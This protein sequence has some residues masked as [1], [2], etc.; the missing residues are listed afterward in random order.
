MPLVS[1]SRMTTFSPCMVGMVA[2]RMS[3]ARPLTEKR[4]RPILG[5]PPFGDV[6]PG[7][8]LDTAHE[9]GTQPSRWGHHVPQDPVDAVTDLQPFTVG[10]DMD[11][12]CVGADRVRDDLIDEADH[13]RFLRQI[14]EVLDIR[15]VGA[16]A[17]HPDIV[18]DPVDRRPTVLEQTREGFLELLCRRYLPHHPPAGGKFNGADRVIVRRIGHGDD[19]FTGPG[20]EWQHLA[21]EKETAGQDV[22]QQWLGR[23]L[24]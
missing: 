6:E 10:F 23:K 3:M 18:E 4:A 16:L 20:P 22:E 8:D 21:V 11:V 13:R 24:G 9:G 1:S 15:F 5:Q 7:K 12:G 2:T 19:H 17:L 14:L